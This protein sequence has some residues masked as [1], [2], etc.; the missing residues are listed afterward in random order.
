MA[1]PFTHTD[2]GQ[3]RVTDLP[4]VVSGGE[5]PSRPGGR[6]PAARPSLPGRS[7]SSSGPGRLLR[8]PPGPLDRVTR[9]SICSESSSSNRTPTVEV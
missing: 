3:K 4:L 2:T 8:S 5:V 9:Q 1:L 6:A 7:A